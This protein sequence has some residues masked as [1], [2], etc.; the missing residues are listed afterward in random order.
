[1]HSPGFRARWQQQPGTD[2][3][4]VSLTMGESFK[5]SIQEWKISPAT[6]TVESGKRL[7]LT[8]RN[9]GTIPHN[10]AVPGLGVRLIGLAPGDTRQVELNAD[11]PGTYQFLCDIGGHAEAGQ[12]GTLTIR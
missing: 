12:R 7:V 11:Q 5:T 8:V 4:L 3:L 10:F 9:D 1:M 2:G 6:L